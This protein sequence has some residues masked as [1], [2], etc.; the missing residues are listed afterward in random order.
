MTTQSSPWLRF[1][2]EIQSIAQNGLAYASNPHDRMRYER[3]R[4]LAAEML[5]EQSNTPLPR[6]TELFCNEQGYQTPKLDCRAAIFAD[7][8]ILLVQEHDGLWALPGG[9]VDVTD[10]LADSIR[11]EVREEAGLEIIPH[12][13]IALH[14][15]N[16]RNLPPYAYGICK[17]FIQCLP[18][19]GSFTANIETIAAAYFPADALPPLNIAK[20]SAEQIALCFAARDISPWQPPF[21]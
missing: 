2:I 16:R 11:K 3:L 15:R 8:C 21:D 1:A 12:K 14:D 6:I 19:H 4:T 5:A 13:I 9:W 17:I 18:C 20:T 7:E 10:S